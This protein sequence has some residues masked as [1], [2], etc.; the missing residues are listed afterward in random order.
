LVN[1]QAGTSAGRLRVL[2]IEDNPDVSDSLR[3]LLEL[4]GHNVTQAG[5]GPAGVAAARADRPDLIFCDLGLPGMDGYGV[6]QALRADSATVQVPLVA[7]SGYAREEDRRRTAAA[8]F[9]AHLG[10]P[11]EFPELE[12]LLARFQPLNGR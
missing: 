6:A 5:T 7:L 9:A 4:L 11:A 12:R 1:G 2:L 10:K 8:G 3:M